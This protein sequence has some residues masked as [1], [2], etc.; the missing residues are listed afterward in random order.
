MRA[1]C[2]LVA[3][4]LGT[5][6]AHADLTGRWA[7][8]PA[9]IKV[10]Q[11]G[12]HL[13]AH[14]A[15]TPANP[16][17]IVAGDLCFQGTVSGDTINAQLVI[18]A[19]AS[20]APGMSTTMPV[21]LKIGDGEQVIEGTFRQTLRF[22]AQKREWRSA[23]TDPVSGKAPGLKR[24]FLKRIP[25]PT[26][27]R[28][29]IISPSGPRT[30]TDLSYNV[31]VIAELLFANAPGEKEYTVEIDTGF[32]RHAVPAVPAADDGKTYRTQP[33]LL[34]ADDAMGLGMP[35]PKRTDRP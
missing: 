23:E 12:M 5:M 9:R 17:G 18:R 11:R 3:L 2:L 13:V 1:E 29:V 33:F 28:F 31:P 7:A 35:P 26:E 8:G 34:A 15:E 14:Y 24:L 16:Y 4:A 27:I 19:E 22:D 6:A 10:D 32:E 25:G 21:A 20:K 30:V